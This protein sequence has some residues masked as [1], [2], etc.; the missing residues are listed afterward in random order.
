MQTFKTLLGTYPHTALIKSGEIASDQFKLNFV[1]Y[2]PVWDGFKSMIRDE[3]F[4]I[5][6]YVTIDGTITPTVATAVGP[7]A[8]DGP[9]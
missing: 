6:S 5:D 1:E 9:R 3:Q 4:D 7:L 8:P 2:N